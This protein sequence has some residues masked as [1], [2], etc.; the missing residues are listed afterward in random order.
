[1]FFKLIKQKKMK[2]TINILLILMIL[3]PGLI[4]SQPKSGNNNFASNN[5]KGNEK[6]EKIAFK[7]D[8]ISIVSLKVFDLLGKEIKTI[9]SETFEEGSYSIDISGIIQSGNSY[10]YKLITENIKGNKS[11]RIIRINP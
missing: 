7:I 10:T 11:E 9:F 3:V 5:P 6:P 2:K 1:M 4:L 8:E